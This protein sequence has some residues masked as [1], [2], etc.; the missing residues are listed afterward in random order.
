[1]AQLVGAENL[2]AVD[3]E[4][5]AK[6][7]IEYGNTAEGSERIRSAREAKQAAESTPANE[8]TPHQAPCP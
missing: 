8:K 2:D 4:T 7:M 1:M 6:R 3:Y 5:F